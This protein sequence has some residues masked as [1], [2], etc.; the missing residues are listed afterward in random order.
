MKRGRRGRGGG[1][2]RMRVAQERAK[3]AC[4]TYQNQTTNFRVRDRGMGEAARRRGVK[5]DTDEEEMRCEE[6]SDES[7]CSMAPMAD[8]GCV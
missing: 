6:R 5:R 2:G 7:V 1:E 8:G 4:A 3:P